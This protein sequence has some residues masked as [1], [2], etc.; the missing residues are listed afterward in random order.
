VIKVSDRE[1]YLRCCQGD[2]EAWSYLYGYV[3]SIARWGRWGLGEAAEDIA[4]AVLLSLMERGLAMVRSADS[5][6]SFVK[7]ATVNRVLDHFRSAEVRLRHRGRPSDEDDS[8][9]AEPIMRHPDG[10]PGVEDQVAG[11][12]DLSRWRGLFE[13]LP[14]YCKSVLHA[15]M[16]YRLGLLESYREIARRVGRPVNTVSVQIKRCLEQLRQVARRAGIM[17]PH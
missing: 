12:R 11:R 2:E 5:F 3:L 14:S 16:D 4:Q 15:Y 7:R 9:G 13:S 6:R 8:P 17:E 10:G 1:L